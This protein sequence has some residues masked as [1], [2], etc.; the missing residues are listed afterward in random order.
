MIDEKC[1]ND[2]GSGC[3]DVV[4]VVICDEDEPFRWPSDYNFCF[5]HGRSE[6]RFP[7]RV[8]QKTFK[9]ATL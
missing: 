2:G 3:S 7:G 1:D 4:V 5:G 6:V 9:N 8:M